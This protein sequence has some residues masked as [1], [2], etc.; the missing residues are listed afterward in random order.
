MSLHAHLVE[1]F[2]GFQVEKV[3]GKMKKK[4]TS[5][6][7]FLCSPNKRCHKKANANMNSLR[8]GVKIYSGAM[9]DGQ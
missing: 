2:H 9:S 5:R 6:L 8:Q 1:G 7:S 4:K 3:G